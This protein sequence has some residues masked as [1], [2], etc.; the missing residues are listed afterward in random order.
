VA[1]GLAAA[2]GCHAFSDLALTAPRLG[3]VVH[4][5]LL[6][7]PALSGAWWLRRPASRPA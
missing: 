3:R 5:V 7:A 1:L 6:L 2:A 4:G